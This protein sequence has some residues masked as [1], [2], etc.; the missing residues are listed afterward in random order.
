[1]E[2]IMKP[3]LSPL[4]PSEIPEWL[5]LGST[6]KPVF[7]KPPALP[8]PLLSIPFTDRSAAPIFL[9]LSQI[10]AAFHPRE[11]LLCFVFPSWLLLTRALPEL[12]LSSLEKSGSLCHIYIRLGRSSQL[13][14]NILNIYLS[15]HH[16][17]RSITAWVIAFL[18]Y[19]SL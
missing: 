4:F 19:V 11:D 6:M 18:K 2:M 13:I 12:S 8:Y 3:S 17:L 15:I 14:H 16:S 9:R 10:Q 7:S 5:I 1:M